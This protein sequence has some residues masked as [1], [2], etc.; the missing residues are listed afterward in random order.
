MD[1]VHKKHILWTKITNTRIFQGWGR[2]GTLNLHS[3]I[4]A[5]DENLD[6]YVQQLKIVY[7]NYRYFLKET[8]LIYVHLQNMLRMGEVSPVIHVTAESSLRTGL[9][10]TLEGLQ[11]YMCV[12]TVRKVTMLNFAFSLLNKRC[13]TRQFDSCLFKMK[14]SHTAEEKTAFHYLKKSEIFLVKIHG[15]ILYQ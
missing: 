10:F 13:Q 4:H 7:L 1:E 3:L 2:V 11:K 14:Y 9:H 5:N 12:L 6:K 8:S 15:I